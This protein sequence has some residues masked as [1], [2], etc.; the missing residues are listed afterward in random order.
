M[1]KPPHSPSKEKTQWSWRHISEAIL[2]REFSTLT[3]YFIFPSLSKSRLRG[4][5]WMLRGIP[6]SRRCC[7]KDHKVFPF[8]LTHVLRK[9]QVHTLP[10]SN[11]IHPRSLYPFALLVHY[12]ST[13]LYWQ[14]RAVLSPLKT[15]TKD[16]NGISAYHSG[17]S[18][19]VDLSERP[20]LVTQTN[21]ITWSHFSHPSASDSLWNS[22]VWALITL[23]PSHSS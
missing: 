19:H 5:S 15:W 10:L 8:R 22:L 6:V 20:S 14:K 7:S 23:C 16:T 4:G 11:F 21:V 12:V 2:S 1:P 18:S 9:T 17:H 3:K 13:G